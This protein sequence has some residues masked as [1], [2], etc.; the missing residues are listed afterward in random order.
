METSLQSHSHHFTSK[1]TPFT[2]INEKVP[3]GP[4]HPIRPGRDP[5]V[6]TSTEE[7]S[8]GPKTVIHL[9][10]AP[11]RTWASESILVAWSPIPV[12]KHAPAAIGMQRRLRSMWHLPKMK[13]HD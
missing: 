8:T 5:D 10:I 1:N 7:S 9:S 13:S 11:S 12:R 3:W 6:P 2:P 4:M